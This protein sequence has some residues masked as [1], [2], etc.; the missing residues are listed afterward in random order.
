VVIKTVESPAFGG[1]TFG[2]VGAYERISGQIVGVVDPKDRRNAV[3]VDFGLAPKNPNGTVSYT[4]DFQILRPIDRGQA[5]SP[6]PVR[7]HQSRAHQCARN[8][9]TTALTPMTSPRPAI[10]ATA[11]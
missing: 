11:S 6:A 1:K 7:D 5:E 4:T 10:P 3:I 2:E 8:N 9:S